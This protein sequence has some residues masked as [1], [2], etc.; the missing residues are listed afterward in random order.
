MAYADFVRMG[1]QKF[2]PAKIGSGVM[3]SSVANATIKGRK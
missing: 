2:N 1:H 3:V